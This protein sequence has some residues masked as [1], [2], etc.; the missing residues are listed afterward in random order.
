MGWDV[1]LGYSVKNKYREKETQRARRGT[2]EVNESTTNTANEDT[3]LFICPIMQIWPVDDKMTHV[4]SWIFPQAAT[5]APE[6]DDA[7]FS[8]ILISLI[9]NHLFDQ[10]LRL[11]CLRK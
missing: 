6:F 5:G 11:C 10:T 4:Y 7:A 1:V 2:A 8:L 3:T 9:L